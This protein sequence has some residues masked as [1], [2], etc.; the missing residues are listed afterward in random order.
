MG[1]P[2]PERFV[3]AGVVVLWILKKQNVIYAMNEVVKAANKMLLPSF[4]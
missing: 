4:C 3:Q 1:L 2:S